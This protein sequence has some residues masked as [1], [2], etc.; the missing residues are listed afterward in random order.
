MA[1]YD[2]LF[3]WVGEPTETGAGMYCHIQKLNSLEVAAMYQQG[4][5]EKQQGVPPHWIVCSGVDSVDL[6]ANKAGFLRGSAIVPLADVSG[7]GLFAVLQ[8]P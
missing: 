8:S 3:G 5:E 7:I 1:F 6:S 2:A 4:D